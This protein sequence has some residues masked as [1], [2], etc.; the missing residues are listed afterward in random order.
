MFDFN[1]A[2]NPSC[3]YDNRW[4]CPRAPAENRLPFPVRAG[5]K[6]FAANKEQ[7]FSMTESQPAEENSLP[8]RQQF[9]E[10]SH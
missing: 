8:F 10:A 4:I 5:E 1:Y 9:T 2:Y 7:R 6:A 3:A